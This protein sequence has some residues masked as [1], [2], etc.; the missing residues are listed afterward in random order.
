MPPSLI[1]SMTTF[2][3]L[4]TSHVDLAV[5][6]NHLHDILI[7]MQFFYMYILCFLTRTLAGKYDPTSV[8]LFFFQSCNHPYN[9]CV[10]YYGNDTSLQC[11][12]CKSKMRILVSLLFI[13]PISSVY[14]VV[15]I[16]PL[17]KTFLKSD[18]FDSFYPFLNLQPNNPTNPLIKISRL[19]RILRINTHTN[20]VDVVKL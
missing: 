14:I 6:A 16:I 4:F 2:N 3:L 1:P 18:R 11:G 5:Y 12:S 10:Y 19:V 17:M 9:M 8:L 13:I 20:V 15:F 7:G